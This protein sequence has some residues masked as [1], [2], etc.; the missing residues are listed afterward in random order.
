MTFDQNGAGYTGHVGIGDGELPFVANIGLDQGAGAIKVSAQAQIAPLPDSID[1]AFSPPGTNQDTN[2]LKVSYDASQ[3]TDIDAHAEI[4]LPGAVANAACGQDLTICADFAG[5]NIPA[6]I[7]ARV[8]DGLH[9]PEGLPE[10]RIELDDIPRPGGV[11][12]DFRAHVVLGQADDAPLGWSC[13]PVTTT[14][15]PVCA[16]PARR[17]RSPRSG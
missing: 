8:K 11:Q 6:H 7:E 4:H 2:P 5:R 16:R 9:T 10:T 1:L 14:T 15:P 13:T 3:T 12:P 17:T